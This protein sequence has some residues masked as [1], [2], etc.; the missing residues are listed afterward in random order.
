MCVCV[1]VCVC[2]CPSF[3]APQWLMTLTAEQLP[4]I[5]SRPL[6]DGESRC[7]GDGAAPGAPH[8]KVLCL[9][10]IH[11]YRTIMYTCYKA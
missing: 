6:E 4:R 2:V 8:V 11:T 10:L 1:C 5:P 7:H 3:S 9:T